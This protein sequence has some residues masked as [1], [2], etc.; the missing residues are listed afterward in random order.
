M[1]VPKT[2]TLNKNKDI[3]QAMSDK[4]LESVLEIATRNTY[5]QSRFNQNT[6]RKTTSISDFSLVKILTIY[7]K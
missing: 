3:R 5:V 6:S 2:N 7:N 4:H 1:H